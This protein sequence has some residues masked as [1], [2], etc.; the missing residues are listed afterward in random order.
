MWR[1]SF[2]ESLHTFV[3]TLAVNPGN[4]L[5]SHLS[6]P[7]GASSQPPTHPHP[8]VIQKQ[9]L[10]ISSSFLNIS[11]LAIRIL[12]C[13]L[14]IMAFFTYK[15][16]IVAAYCHILIWFFKS[17][18][19]LIINFYLFNNVTG[20]KSHSIEAIKS[21][22]PSPTSRSLTSAEPLLSLVSAF[23]SR[24]CI[25]KRFLKTTGS[26]C[27]T[28]SPIFPHLPSISWPSFHSSTCRS[29]LFLLFHCISLSSC[30]I[31]KPLPCWC[32]FWLFLSFLLFKQYCNYIHLPIFCDKFLEIGYCIK[33]HIF[34]QNF[35]H[36][37]KLSSKKMW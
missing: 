37:T 7:L 25:F 10:G 24:L 4:L 14:I 31:T 30:M 21:E 18:I 11:L 32:T 35:S 6:G 26:Y 22:S 16:L 34:I 20:N 29:I 5:L 17:K 33:G 1:E 12:S 36:I 2:S 13:N 28:S 15:K 23:R 27:I 8:W 3:F 19:V 9:L